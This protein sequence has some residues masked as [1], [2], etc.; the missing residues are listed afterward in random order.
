MASW[1]IDT[2]ARPGVL[3]MTLSGAFTTDEME[4]VRRAHNAAIDAFVGGDYRVFVDLRDLTPFSPEC[5]EIMEACKL[6]SSS[7]PNFQGS[8]VLAS[9]KI[10]ALQH[11]R[12]SVAG[13]VVGTELI[14]EDFAACEE[15]LARVHRSSSR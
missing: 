3:V 14:S 6:Y 5:A 12:T 13:G 9:S 1:K 10:V 7:R 2:D 4:E 8:A 15:H 11:Q